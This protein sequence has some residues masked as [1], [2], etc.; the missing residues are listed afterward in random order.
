ME[1]NIYLRY[2]L[3]FSSIYPAAILCF[4]PVFNLMKKPIQTISSCF[5]I[6]TLICLIA[7][8][9]CTKF[10]LKSN[11]LF[12]PTILFFLFMYC[13]LLK[14][15]IS[16]QK[17]TF[18]FFIATLLSAVSVLLSL[19]FNARKE[20]NDNQEIV[21][22]ASTSLISIIIAT[23]I[24]I[25]YCLFFS[26]YIKWLVL[27]FENESVWRF[28]WIVPAIF[29]VFYIY[30]K[31]IDTS[32]VLINRM[33]IIS[34][35][36]I[37]ASLTM[38]FIFIYMFYCVAKEF[39]ENL[40]LIRQNQIF[41]YESRRY[42]ELREN[43]E[44]TRH[45]R[46]DFRQHLRVISGLT[47]SGKLDELKSYLDQYD[48]LLENESITLCANAA[49][50]AIAGYYRLESKNSGIDTQWHIE[51]PEKLSFSESDL[52]I[53]LGNLLENAVRCSR[54]A[55][56]ENRKMTVICRMVTPAMLGIIVENTYGG[57]LDCRNG[58]FYSTSHEGKGTGLVSVETVVKKYNG[59]L[60]IE[61][62]NG[63]FKV[64]VL[65]NV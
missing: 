45:Q 17:L 4:A 9:I 51:L 35:M 32:T 44:K 19:I 49:I 16:S 34:V 26:K 20:T 56:R 30:V 50:D 59:E 11:I 28:I 65:M 61:T 39:Q 3:D 13:T 47:S 29:T 24:C 53:V 2:F 27:E 42:E 21:C 23:I 25:V 46:H 58:V 37:I 38:F 52:C 55:K 8:E 7:S 1:K 41:S 12:L 57:K 48:V 36:S 40:K 62:E 43:M 54:S 6:I 10:T 22:L 64:N 15:K 5:G 18:I 31:P 60:K 33:P 14:N 63:V